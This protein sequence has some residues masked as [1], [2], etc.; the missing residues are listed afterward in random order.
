MCKVSRNRLGNCTNRFQGNSIRVL[1]VCSA[2][3][4]RS[5]TIAR[6]LTKVFDKVN[7]RAVGTSDDF[8]L[9]PLDLVHLTW[10]ELII[11]ANGEVL[12]FVKHAL[13]LAKLDRP[14][15]DFDIPDDF[16]F[17]DPVLEEII[18]QE[19]AIIRGLSIDEVRE[20]VVEAVKLI[21]L[22]E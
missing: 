22:M 7:T 14:V 20:D 3:L 12:E 15:I 21:Q 11:C 5:P 16:G 6:V 1:T 19:I 8:A 10:A 4:L 13:E 9:I 17:A 2:G 18:R